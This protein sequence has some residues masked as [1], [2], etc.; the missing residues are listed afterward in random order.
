MEKFLIENNLLNDEL[1]RDMCLYNFFENGQSKN[2]E[3]ILGIIAAKAEIIRRKEILDVKN[4]YNW[5]NETFR[6]QVL[7]VIKTKIKNHQ[8][9]AA[10]N[11]SNEISDQK[12]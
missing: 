1:N 12:K 3:S 6:E 9:T 8:K 2:I 11:T 4:Q 10:N 5:N 7:Q